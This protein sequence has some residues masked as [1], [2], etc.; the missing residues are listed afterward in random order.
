MGKLSYEMKQI[1]EKAQREANGS[2]EE[3]GIWK[4]TD[5][6]HNAKHM[7]YVTAPVNPQ[8]SFHSRYKAFFVDSVYPAGANNEK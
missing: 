5:D 3:I 7:I 4:I 2:G 6:V 8:P 1:L